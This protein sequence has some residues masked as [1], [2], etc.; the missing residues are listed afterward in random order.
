M[1]LQTSIIVNLTLWV[2]QPAQAQD[3]KA[4]RGEVE[5]YP[6]K[7]WNS[8]SLDFMAAN[9]QE[10]K[11]I[12]AE[13]KWKEL[14]KLGQSTGM[15][16]VH[17]GFVIREFGDCATPVPCHSIRKSFLSAVFGAWIQDTGT[18]LDNLLQTKISEIPLTEKGGIPK[19]YQ[20]ATIQQ[21][22]KSCS[23]I[24]LAAE[25]E[26]KAFFLKRTK[27]PTLPGKRWAYSNWDFNAL[28]T[29]FQI[30]S[31]MNLFQAFDELVAKPI[32]MEDFDKEQDTMNF[33]RR[34]EPTKSL[35]PAYLFKL[36]ARDR[37][38]F[39][40]LYLSGGMWEN[41]RIIDKTWFEKSI[42]DTITAEGH[43]P[44]ASS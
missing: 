41:N 23:G 13:N 7:T 29:T 19:E 33:P 35:H 16:I 42:T 27:E 15:M 37:A 34:G 4:P 17:K 3:I 28:G 40:L 14:H 36:S 30:K 38:R 8:P 31:G 6:A 11:L 5:E 32:G 26:S 12:E 9:W 24:P 20:D 22:L 25:Y 2:S 1:K 21:M 18:E 43:G 44:S 10:A 39:G